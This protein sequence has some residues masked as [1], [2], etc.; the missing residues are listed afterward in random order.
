LSDPHGTSNSILWYPL[1]NDTQHKG[2]TCSFHG[3]TSR[4]SNSGS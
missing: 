2:F 4:S 1:E 3:Y